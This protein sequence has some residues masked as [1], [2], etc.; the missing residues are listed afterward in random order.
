MET[1]ME[2]QQF[3]LTFGFSEIE[4]LLMAWVSS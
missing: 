4:L 2:I 3:I 1:K